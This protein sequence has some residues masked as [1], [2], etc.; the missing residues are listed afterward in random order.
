MGGDLWERFICCPKEPQR[1]KSTAPLP[2]C[3]AVLVGV[4]A[5]TDEEPC[6]GSQKR[7]RIRILSKITELKMEPQHSLP[8]GPLLMSKER[9]LIMQSRLS[10]FT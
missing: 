10:S 4:L 1:S 2:P 3:K 9:F 6:A 5:V 8:P 7:Q